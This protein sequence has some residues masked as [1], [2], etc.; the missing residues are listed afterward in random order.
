MRRLLKRLPLKQVIAWTLSTVAAGML[1]WWG[2]HTV[3]EAT[4]YPPPVAVALTEERV[5]AE[6]RST[7]RPSYS[8]RPNTP[9]DSPDPAPAG[10][11]SE[12]SGRP[13]SKPSEPSE[14]SGPSGPSA[15]AGAPP[16]PERGG[17]SPSGGPSGGAVA[18]GA[19]GGGSGSASGEVKGYAVDGGR[20]TFDMGRDS[21]ELVSATPNA[22]W[23][24]QV[25]HHP[26]WIRVTFTRGEREINVFCSWH[27]HPPLVE[28]EGQ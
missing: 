9:A 21:A 11:E 18:D 26:Q 24:M 15:D 8:Y 5:D 22:G 20:V 6:S 28:I 10:E 1:S 19:P 14:P 12:P 3:M 4:A 13:E 17:A 23:R 27:E 7:P 25:W 2:V 16:V